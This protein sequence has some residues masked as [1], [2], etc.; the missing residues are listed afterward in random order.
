MV[1]PA[2][3]PIEEIQ[4]DCPPGAGPAHVALRAFHCRWPSGDPAGADFKFCCASKSDISKPYCSKHAALVY[5][6]RSAARKAD[7]GQAA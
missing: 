7:W 5:V 6:P 4:F 3:S 1:T 2:V